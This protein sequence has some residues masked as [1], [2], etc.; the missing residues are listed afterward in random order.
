MAIGRGQGPNQ[1]HMNVRESGG[2]EGNNHRSEMSVAVDF[3]CLTREAG[4]APEGNISG[5]M[6]PDISGREETTSSSNA[7]M[8]QSMNMLEENMLKRLRDKGT[9]NCGG[10]ITKERGSPTI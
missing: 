3:A 8:S 7:W 5:K 4:T 10:E 1:I 2:G 9:K 6:W